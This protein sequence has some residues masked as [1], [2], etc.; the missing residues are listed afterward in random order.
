MLATLS[1]VYEQII[2]PGFDMLINMALPDMKKVWS[3]S[4][5]G[6]F[7][8]FNLFF[9]KSR[10]FPNYSKILK[11]YLQF[12]EMVADFIRGL[13]FHYRLKALLKLG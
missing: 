13:K 3:E 5:G 4:N 9:C 10:F 12:H 1:K 7:F 6:F 11:C 2:E 8:A